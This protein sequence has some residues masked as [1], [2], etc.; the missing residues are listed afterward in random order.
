MKDNLVL[1]FVFINS[2]EIRI[3]HEN[4]QSKTAQT[5]VLYLKVYKATG[6]WNNFVDLYIFNCQ[7]VFDIKP[8]A[9]MICKVEELL[10]M[11]RQVW[12]Y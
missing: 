2:I 7:V 10:G 12:A 4:T 8:T 11:P 5:P 1:K 9:S 6:S 3:I